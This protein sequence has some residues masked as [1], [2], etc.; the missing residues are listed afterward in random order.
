MK[1]IWEKTKKT[2][3]VAKAKVED[4]LKKG[5]AEEDPDFKVKVEQLTFMT[6]KANAILTAINNY[7]SVAQKLSVDATVVASAY[8]DAFTPEDSPYKQN[9]DQFKTAADDFSTI[10][11]NLV[12]SRIPQQVIQPL[13]NVTNEITRLRLIEKKR[14]KNRALLNQAEAHLK[15]A[16]EKCKNVSQAEEAAAHRRAKY[17]KYH[18]EFITGVSTLYEKRGE[19]FGASLNAFQFYVVETTEELKKRIASQLASFPYTQL[20][21]QIP[22]MTVIDPVPEQ[23]APQAAQQP[24]TA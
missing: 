3:T 24:A 15:T 10:I 6:Q 8:S 21:G 13:V 17:T 19:T 12:E 16:R 5:E 20:Q 18:N 22:S 9:A 4:T 14:Y 11:N 7:K 23:P 1:K 2:A